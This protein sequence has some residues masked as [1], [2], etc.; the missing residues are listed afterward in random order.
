MINDGEIVAADINASLKSPAAG[1]EG[2]RSLGT[3][4]TQAAPGNDSRFVPTGCMMMWPT[5]TPP[6]GWILCDGGSTA[7]YPALAAV[8]GANVPD[9]RDKFAQGVGP[10]NALNAT[11]G[12]A[13]MPG[14]THDIGDHYHNATSSPGFPNS[15][16]GAL[17]ANNDAGAVHVH[18]ID[19]GNTTGSSTSS[20]QKTNGTIANTGATGPY[21]PTNSGGHT[22]AI[23][24]RTASSQ[25]QNTGSTG[26]GN[27]SNENR[28]PFL[29][30][31]FIIKT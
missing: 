3:G 19:I 21:N 13:G 6:A 24:G 16:T 23:S 26:S 28:P 2:L 29:T 11:G 25:M 7:S 27:T 12:Q 22:H 9:M 4:S 10:L 8:V 15:S 17:N 30:V 18:P 20:L 5:A 31:N 14:H 1:V